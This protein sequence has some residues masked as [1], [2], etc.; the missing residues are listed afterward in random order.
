V[1]LADGRDLYNQATTA[2]GYACAS[3][4]LVRFGLGTS[5]A[6]ERVEIQ[7]PGGG[8]QQIS[9]VAGDRVVD[10]VEEVKP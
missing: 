10:V 9:N 3:E 5:Q 8:V 1:H 4:P 2:V 7:W 6:A